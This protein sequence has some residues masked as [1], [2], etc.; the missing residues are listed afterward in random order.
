MLQQNGYPIKII[1]NVIRKA[2][3]KNQ[4]PDAKLRPNQQQ[5]T[6]HCVFFKLQFIDLISKQIE[7]EIRKFLCAYGIILIMSH[8]NFTIGKQFSFKDRQSLLLSS[9]VVHRLTS[10][11]GQNY[12][13]Q[14]KRNLTTRLNEHQ[15]CE[16]TEV[17][18][19]LLNNPDHEINFDSPKILD[20]S[21]Q[22]AK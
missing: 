7:K 20:R 16:D 19:H 6:K 14:T 21:N 9:G 18:E 4:N 3:N 12:I 10:S 11:C 5:S 1:W 17:C 15:T 22:V 8:C 2:M 13:G